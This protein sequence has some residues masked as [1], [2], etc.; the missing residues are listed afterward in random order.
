MPPLALLALVPLFGG[1]PHGE[2][3][4][5]T[6]KDRKKP[7]S[8]WPFG[9]CDKKV[10][11][12]RCDAFFRLVDLD[13]DGR[14]EILLVEYW[15]K[16]LTLITTTDP[17]GSFA[18]A[19]KLRYLTIDADVGHAFDFELVDS[20]DGKTDLLVTNHQNATEVPTGS[21]FACEIPADFL[22]SPSSA[23]TKHTKVKNIPVNR[24]GA[25]PGVAGVSARVYPPR[26]A[27]TGKTKPWI[28]ASGDG[29]QL[30][31]VIVPA[32]PEEPEEPEE[33]SD[34]VLHDC[35]NTVGDVGGRGCGWGW[36]DGR[37]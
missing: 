2:L 13:N 26:A 6:P 27:D 3:V 5:F 31:H 18:D 9:G 17:K 30:V 7:L 4:Y 37:A 20:G 10:I 14:I 28:V 23:W 12:L 36:V 21:V 29:S 22:N 16:V 24:P 19:T 35:N 11:G 32:K 25:K 15:G 8:S 34:L 33:P 1:A